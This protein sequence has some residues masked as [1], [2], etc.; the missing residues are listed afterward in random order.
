M[1]LL[2]LDV[3]YTTKSTE[4][5]L[6][7]PSEAAWNTD[8]PKQNVLFWLGRVV[9]WVGWRIFNASGI[10]THSLLQESNK[11]QMPTQ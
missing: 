8:L 6:Q 7:F 5:N 11:T 10:V 3:P 9:D 2:P 4:G 1:V